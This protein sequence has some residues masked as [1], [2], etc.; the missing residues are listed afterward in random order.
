VKRRTIALLL[1][2]FLFVWW[3]SSRGVQVEPGSVLVE[4]LEGQYVDSAEPPLLA[5]LAGGDSRTLGSLLSDL[6][7]AER[8]DRLAAVVL[9]VR[10]LDIGWG[11]AQEI[12]DAIARLNAAGRRTIAYL[13][14]ESFGGNLEYYVASAAQELYVAPATSAPLVG[15]A[16]EYLFFGGLFEKLGIDLEVERVGRYKSAAETIAGREMSAAHREMQEALLD[17]ID[18]QFVAGIAAGRRLSEEAVR[19]AIDAAPAGA[20][21]LGALGLVD[22]ARSFDQVVRLAGEG[23]IVEG[24]T[25][26]G[27]DP[28]SVG[29]E[30]VATFALVYGSGNVVVGEG[31]QTPTG[32]A[33]LASDTVAQALE[34][35]AEDPDVAAI[36]F[37]IDSPGGSALASDIVWRAVQKARESGK[38]LVASFS[39]V[40]ASG[41]YYVAAGADAI[42]AQPA[43]ITGSIGV[44]AL[45]PVTAGLLEK[46]DI[47][48][49]SLTRGAH[50]DLQLS[51]R[52]LSPSSR[53]RLRSEVRAVYDLFVERV[54]NG[55]PLDAEGVDAV[56]RG[57]VW[58]GA[59]AAERGLVDELGGLD[60]ALA[61]AKHQLG[62]DPGADIELVP[63]PRPRTL[64][65]QLGD[66]VRQLRLELAAASPLALWTR[67]WEPWLAAAREPGPVALLPF[68]VEIR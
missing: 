30:P 61:R 41:G 10:S 8:D 24:D 29:I 50:A 49:T 66:V 28:A 25:Y 16:G 33:V 59:Q 44:F 40:A 56:G 37:R 47:G 7:K 12:R 62:I 3:L 38:P 36:V 45:R 18:A 26:R 1:V 54:A 48:F 65:E 64:A 58:T 23:P 21:E 51:S 35:A 27:V 19:K 9:R 55:R 43:S 4:V 14:I 46:L 22:G 67:H 5:R 53:E 39:D 68:A 6:E 13:E 2:L 11:K 34:D 15:L 20:D 57:R 60:T 17:S 32:S 31:V 63:Y 42:V 52:P